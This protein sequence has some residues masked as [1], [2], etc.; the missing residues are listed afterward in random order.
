M[1]D[2]CIVVATQVVEVSLDISFDMM[3]TETAPIDALIQRFGRIN[4]K[5]DFT[6]IGKYKPIYILAPPEKEKDAKP[7]SLHVLQQSFNV[8]PKGE[9]LKESAIQSLID[10][11]YPVIE[12]IDI[13][14]DAAFVNNQWRITE[15]RHFPK[16][17]LLEK[18]DIDS[19]ACITENDRNVYTNAT[20]EQQILME[21]PVT[22]NSVRWKNLEQLSVGTHPFIVPDKAYSDERGLDFFKTNIEH[23]DVTYQIL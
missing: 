4:R 7:Y 15:L 12:R 18:L 3:I 1:D 10:E 22:Y 21:I 2:A 8:L 9:L 20:H 11:V 17:A 14:L 5:R 19:V 16:S 13:D 23:Y 6:T